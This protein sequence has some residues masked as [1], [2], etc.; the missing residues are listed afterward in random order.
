MTEMNN[1]GF[2]S[3]RTQMPDNMADLDHLFSVAAVEYHKERIQEVSSKYVDHIYVDDTIYQGELTLNEDMQRRTNE[4]EQI[5]AETSEYPDAEVGYYMA[6]KQVFHDHLNEHD[7]RS[8]LLFATSQKGSRHDAAR[9]LYL[10][11]YIARRNMDIG[12]NKTVSELLP[13]NITQMPTE[14]VIAVHELMDEAIIP[15]RND[16]MDT[17]LEIDGSEDSMRIM[18]EIQSDDQH[19]TQIYAWAV[20]AMMNMPNE[21]GELGQEFRNQNS[22]NLIVG[23]DCTTMS[24]MKKARIYDALSWLL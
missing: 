18:G 24:E 16:I 6:Q 13:V 10:H 15:D 3:E 8:A 12:W 17:I 9:R 19:R 20:A 5:Y 14:D 22:Q 21:Q 1:D 2:D 11:E 4:V 7:F 23:L